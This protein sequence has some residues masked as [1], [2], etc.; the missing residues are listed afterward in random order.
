MGQ[1]VRR[2][3]ASVQPS[4]YLAFSNL[5]D[6]RQ[7]A[8]TCSLVE[9]QT[10]DAYR[11]VRSC[12]R[13]SVAVC[14]RH[15]RRVSS[16][17]GGGATGGGASDM[18][19]RWGR[20]CADWTGLGESPSRKF[21]GVLNKTAHASFENSEKGKGEKHVSL[22]FFLLPCFPQRPARLRSRRSPP[23]HAH[24]PSQKGFSQFQQWASS[25]LSRTRLTSSATRSSTDADDKT[26]LIT[27]R[28]SPWSIRTRTSTRR[29]STA[30]S[31][32]SYVLCARPALLLHCFLSALFATRLFC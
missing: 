5:I 16:S 18:F 6:A 2:A 11:V 27:R 23:P 29:R 3:I 4:V 22:I 25:R 20:R 32:A 13:S 14:A 30:L 21:Q 24:L 8:S 17:G 1:G 31:F 28:A 19:Q 10:R 7:R 12:C 9:E 15:R 26:R